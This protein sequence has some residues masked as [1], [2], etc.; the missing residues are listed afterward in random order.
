MWSRYLSVTDRLSD[1]RTDWLA[2]LPQQYRALRSIARKNSK[3]SNITDSNRSTGQFLYFMVR[4]V[5]FWNERLVPYIACDSNLNLLNSWLL[6]CYCIASHCL[7]DICLIFVN[8]N[9][10][11]KAN[12]YQ[13][14]PMD[15]V[16]HISY[17]LCKAV[18]CEFTHFI[19]DCIDDLVFHS[20][21][22]S[23]I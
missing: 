14:Y 4:I 21:M 13:P 11:Q 23:Q 19:P 5:V 10:L 7:L 3:N 1:R 12:D 15:Q 20:W 22:E 2:T 18:S 16:R 17:Q 8:D 9:V 6:F